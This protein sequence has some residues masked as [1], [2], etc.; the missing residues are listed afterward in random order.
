V[1]V[2]RDQWGVPHIYAQNVDDLFFAQGYVMAQDR[3]WQ[4]EWWRREREGRLAEILG[5]A[6]V[7]RDRLTRLTKFRGP[8]DE[9]EWT[10][11]HPEGKRLAEAYVQGVNAYIAAN[12]GNLPVE[13]K[14]T[15]IRPEP[16]TPET[17]VLRANQRVLGDAASELRLAQSV[18]QLG[19]VEANRRADPD[20][21][22]VLK[23]PEGLNVNIIGEEVLRSLR[24]GGARLP[25]PEI[26]E[27]YRKFFRRAASGWLP[28]GLIGEPGSNNWVM[29]DR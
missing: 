23:V 1:E 22:E 6:A 27:P 3:L 21:W 16:W 20:P 26:V 5:P 18:A 29:S 9:R 17:V 4:M 2:I 25:K 10:R 28:L 14:L 13:F 12:A 15:G 11:Y 19:A 7:E 24:P 8:F